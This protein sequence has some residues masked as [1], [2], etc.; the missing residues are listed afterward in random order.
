MTNWANPTLTS[1]YTDFLSQLKERDEDLAKQ[2]DGQTVSNL[3]TGTIRWNS[4]VNRWQKWSGSAWGELTTTYALTGLSTTGNAA[5]GGTL[6]VTG[7]TSLAAGTAAAPGLYLG[8]DSTTGFFRAGTNVVGFSTSGT[9]SLRLQSGALLIGTQSNAGNA[10]LR[11]GREITGGAT[12]F[13]TRVVASIASDV[14]GTGG[15]F[16]SDLTVAD[17]AALN[18][19]TSYSA[20]SPVLGTGSSIQS[21][22]GFFCGSMSG[23]TANYAFAGTSAS[24]TG[25]WN[26]YMSGSA[27]NYFAGD[28]RTNTVITQRTVPA[29]A[30]SNF[31]ATAGS[32]LTG[33][34]TGTPTSSVTLQVPTGTNM[35]AVFQE[36]QNDH[37]INWYVIN[38]A[39]ATHTITVTS[40]TDHTLVGNMVVAANSSAGFMTRKTAAN[41]FITYRVG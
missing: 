30:N 39:A 38:L 1:L 17:G 20:I 31:T 22:Y 26:C 24:A 5:I 16:R 34:R 23:A 11:I 32:L 29:N 14:T 41:T 7:V 18:V 19:V 6:S 37:A 33:I 21:S 4:S 25:V 13:A 40:N 35:D 8:A 9:E 3:I 36:L 12:C 28:V 2:F 10:A 15:S 27:P